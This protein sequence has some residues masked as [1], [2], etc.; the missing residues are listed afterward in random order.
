MKDPNRVRKLLQGTAKLEF[1]LTEDFAKVYPY[2]DAANKKAALLL[3]GDTTKGD[4]LAAASKLKEND[5][6]TLADK[7][8]NEQDTTKEKEGSLISK[9]KKDTTGSK[10]LKSKKSQEQSAKENPLFTYL[11]P[12]FE[13]KADGKYYYG[14][15]PVVGFCAIID[16]A[17]VNKILSMDQVKSVFPSQYKF[18][19][20]VKPFD[21]K[22]TTLAFIHH[23]NG[24]RRESAD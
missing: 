1:W 23:Q 16:T 17:K 14:K 24:Q 18:L 9:A 21:E 2:M 10:E 20:D 15:G 8:R 22:K 13:Q 4:T 6:T 11:R 12:N 19:W 5:K 7:A 3:K